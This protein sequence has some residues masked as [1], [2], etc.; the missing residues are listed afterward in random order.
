MTGEITLTGNVLPIGGLK[1]KIL[2]G[3]RAG[4]KTVIAPATNKVD[5]EEDFPDGID[6][7]MNMIYV[8]N[9]EDVL[10]NALEK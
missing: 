5:V 2:G 4:I 1:E 8:E 9:A 3:K 6:G 10:K 7:I